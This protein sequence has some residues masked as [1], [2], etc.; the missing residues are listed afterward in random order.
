MKKQRVYSW[1]LGTWTGRWLRFPKVETRH[2]TVEITFE[3]GRVGKPDR[4]VTIGLEDQCLARLVDQ[5]QGALRE[6]RES[7]KRQYQS[8]D[9][10][11]LR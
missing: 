6:R 8:W 10:R 1:N 5:L 4:R 11:I 2:N 7:A 9:S 3:E